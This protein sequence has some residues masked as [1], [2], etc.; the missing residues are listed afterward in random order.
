[1]SNERNPIGKKAE[2]T[3]VVFFNFQDIIPKEAP[4]IRKKNK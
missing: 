1:M 3:G 2:A 4:Q